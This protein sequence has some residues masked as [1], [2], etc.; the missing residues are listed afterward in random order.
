MME[1]LAGDIGGT[2][3]ILRLVRCHDQ[4]STSPET[5]HEHR[6]VSS[7]YADLVPMVKDF[8]AAAPGDPQPQSACFA[9]AGPVVNNRSQLTN[10]AWSLEADRI[11][12][13]LEIGQVELINDFAAVGY[14][15]LGLQPED[16]YTLQ[17]GI[18]NPAA[19]IAI[20]GAGTGLGQGFLINC[21]G[22]HQVFPSEG[23]HVDFAPRSELE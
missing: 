6:Y 3:T 18:P 20:I 22:Q 16:T 8:L 14:G 5:L 15:V 11:A 2:K 13:E 23:G 1:L 9:I 7:D 10:L 21:N 12:E 19:P 17:A 4:P